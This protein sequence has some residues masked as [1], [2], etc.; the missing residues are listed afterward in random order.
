MNAVFFHCVLTQHLQNKWAL[1]FL[2]HLRFDRAVLSKT[3]RSC[4]CWVIKIGSRFCG[5]ENLPSQIWYVFSPKIFLD[6]SLVSFCPLLIRSKVKAAS[7]TTFISQILIWVCVIRKVSLMTNPMENCLLTLQ[8]PSALGSFLVSF[9][10]LLWFCSLQLYYFWFSLTAVIN[11]ISGSC[12]Q[13][14]Q[15]KGCNSKAA[16][17]C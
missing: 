15:W 11:L 14:F 16:T 7:I 12:R 4:G 13:H 1:S 5:R 3:R 9:S 17:V 6:K 10:S 8:F 2:E